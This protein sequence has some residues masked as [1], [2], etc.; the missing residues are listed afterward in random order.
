MISAKT[1]MPANMNWTV[2]VIDS[3]AA[4][5]H[6]ANVQELNSRFKYLPSN[7]TR[8]RL[9][10]SNVIEGAKYNITVCAQ[11]RLTEKMEMACDSIITER[12][13][14]EIPKI[15]FAKATMEICPS[16]TLKLRGELDNLLA[17]T[18]EFKTE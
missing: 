18:H 12:V 3:P 4:S 13:G 16:R 9:N 17:G 1:N 2:A 15:K 14:K 5:R 6:T 10:A 8:I 7:Q 11:E